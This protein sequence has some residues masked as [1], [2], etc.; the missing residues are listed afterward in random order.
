MNFKIV[1]I[2]VCLLIFNAKILN[3]MESGFKKLPRNSIKLYSSSLSV[4]C[5]DLP[6]RRSLDA[7]PI[8]KQSASCDS[9]PQV[10]SFRKLTRKGSAIISRTLSLTK[11][12]DGKKEKSSQ[13]LLNEKF[14]KFV[15]KLDIDGVS[16]ALEKGADINSQDTEGNTAFMKIIKLLP[17]EIS[18]FSFK[19]KSDERLTQERLAAEIFT[20]LSNKP[21]FNPAITNHRGE[22]LFDIADK[23]KLTKKA[24]QFVNLSIPDINDNEK[25]ERA[26][27]LFK[28]MQL[29]D[30][31]REKRLKIARE[32]IKDEKL[33]RMLKEIRFY[34]YLTHPK[35]L[36]RRN[37]AI[38]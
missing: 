31:E 34:R 2:N 15:E 6:E 36:E 20:L 37:S 7:D 18:F 25:M 23:I 3:C 22:T 29:D 33:R 38:F 9:L 14:L 30:Y 19:K 21:I 32:K 27:L 5:P 35:R 4:S 10:G 26:R 1:Y 8:K 11:M 12:T 17:Q 16:L 13:E 24:A 28:Q